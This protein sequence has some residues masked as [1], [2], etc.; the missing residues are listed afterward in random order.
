MGQ[1]AGAF[2]DS[3]LHSNELRVLVD[4]TKKFPDDFLLW[5]LLSQSTSATPEQKAEAQAQ[6]KRL[7][8]LNPELK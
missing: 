2:A 6:I 4:G 7:D 1:I 3:K 8:P 5:N